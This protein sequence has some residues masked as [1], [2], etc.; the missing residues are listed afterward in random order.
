MRRGDLQHSHQPRHRVLRAVPGWLMLRR[1]RL[2]VDVHALCCGD[3]QRHGV[4]YWRLRWCWRT[5]TGSLLR[6]ECHVRGTTPC[7]PGTYS[8]N[9]TFSDTCD[10]NC[11]LAPGSYCG[12]GATSAAAVPCAA[13]TFSTAGAYTSAAMGL[14]PPPVPTCAALGPRPLPANPPTTRSCLCPCPSVGLRKSTRPR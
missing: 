5:D 10:G 14:V 9:G 8:V 7:P 1:R 3:F 13:G 6:Y 4:R 11:T 2:H 12:A